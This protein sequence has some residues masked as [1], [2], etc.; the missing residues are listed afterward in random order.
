MRRAESAVAGLGWLCLDPAG[1]EIKRY[2]GQG[3]Y[4]LD[5]QIVGEEVEAR[6]GTGEVPP[7]VTQRD[8]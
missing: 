6:P 8:G 5:H 4:L 3:D 7:A 2:V 1:P